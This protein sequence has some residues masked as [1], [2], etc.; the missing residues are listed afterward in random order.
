M[1]WV[2]QW[3]A[4]LGPACAR[5]CRLVA[6]QQR[7]RCT[8]VVPRA[9]LHLT[10]RCTTAVARLAIARQMHAGALGLDAATLGAVTQELT[11]HEALAVAAQ[12]R[13][14]VSP[15]ASAAAAGLTPPLV[16]R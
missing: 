9:C 6:A 16:W 15:C 4:A 12:R 8:T 2:M 1:Q 10:A 3:V 11:M 14:A 7:T 13:V 5:A